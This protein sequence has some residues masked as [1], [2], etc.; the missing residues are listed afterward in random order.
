MSSKTNSIRLTSSRMVCCDNDEWRTP[1]ELSGI[2]FREDDDGIVAT[3]VSPD[4]VV[5]QGWGI[6][7]L[8]ALDS[9]FCNNQD[10]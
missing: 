7:R 5:V 3:Y 4:S 6:T 9:L 2:H 10:W 8:S 1:V